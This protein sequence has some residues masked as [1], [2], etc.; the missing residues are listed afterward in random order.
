[1][2][3]A[4]AKMYR[5]IRAECKALLLFLLENQFVMD[6]ESGAIRQCIKGSG[7]GLCGE[8][9]LILRPPPASQPDSQTAV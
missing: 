1:M 2:N 3:F 8:A 9:A 5:D 7:M 4:G 6:P